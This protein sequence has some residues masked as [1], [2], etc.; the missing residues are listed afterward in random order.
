M[1]VPRNLCSVPARSELYG[2]DRLI[3]DLFSDFRLSAPTF[4]GTRFFPAVNSWEDEK[5]YHVELELP[6]FDK[7]DL[8]ISVHGNV[9]EISG[10]RSEEKDENTTWHR[11]ERYVGRF[12]RKL[13]FPA[14][15]DH[16]KVEA[17][18]EN[19][20]LTVVLP[21]AETAM[22]RKIQVKG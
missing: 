8:E 22:P 4:S 10:E 6:G 12:S 3:D 20:I 9:L 15:A 14:G 17:H 2:I 19:G 21:K 18:Y 7:K 11:R 1:L 5:S 16:S 13:R